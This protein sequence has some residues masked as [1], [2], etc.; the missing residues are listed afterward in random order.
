MIATVAPKVDDRALEIG[1]GS[2]YSAAVLASIVK[3]VYTVERIAGLAD[4]AARRLTDL[5]YRNVHVRMR[6]RYA[7][8]AGTCAVRHHHRDGGRPSRTIGPPRPAGDGRSPRHGQ[9]LEAVSFVPLIGAQGWPDRGGE[10]Q[11]GRRSRSG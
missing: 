1:T 9:Q 7:W 2:G 5:G 8:L 10:G 6:R 4:T 3:E 11:L